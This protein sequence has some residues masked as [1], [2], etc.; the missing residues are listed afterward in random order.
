MKNKHYI[1]NG[2]VK[3][4][5]YNCAECPWSFVYNGYLCCGN[6]SDNLEIG[7]YAENG[8]YELPKWCPKCKEDK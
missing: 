2:T 1:H 3:I 4:A 5:I 6:T 8:Y 7:V